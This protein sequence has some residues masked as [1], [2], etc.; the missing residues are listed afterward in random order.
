MNKDRRHAAQL[1][2]ELL[3]ECSAVGL[4]SDDSHV[5]VTDTLK[6]LQQ[7]EYW[8]LRGQEKHAGKNPSTDSQ[9]AICRVALPALEAAVTA[10][11]TDDFDAVIDQLTLAVTT[12]GTVPTRKKVKK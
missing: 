11:E 12:D 5:A 9:I 6:H 10:W 2:I 7:A 3:K 8:Q 1:A 4:I